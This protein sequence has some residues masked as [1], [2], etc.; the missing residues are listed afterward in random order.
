MTN[1]Q[2]PSP[3]EVRCDVCGVNPAVGGHA[4]GIG[5]FSFSDCASCRAKHAE[6]YKDVVDATA[7]LWGHRDALDEHGTLVVAASCAVAGK[8]LEEFDADVRAVREAEG[9]HADGSQ[10]AIEARGQARVVEADLLSFD[11]VVIPIATTRRSR[12]A[13]G[14]AIVR[15]KKMVL[16]DLELGESHFRRAPAAQGGQGYVFIAVSEADAESG[17][18]PTMSKQGA[19]DA[20]RVA[21]AVAASE[22]IAKLAVP[23]F[24]DADGSALVGTMEAAIE[25]LA[26]DLPI[27]EVVFVT[28]ENLG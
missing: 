17:A 28:D 27:P 19:Y 9:R 22:Q 3:R 10:A 6:P 2:A 11:D 16:P 4:S 21:V 8:T 1:K 26:V 20:T 12:D 23:V 24:I 13:V 18:Q 25:D 14:E 15:E 5:P 7:L